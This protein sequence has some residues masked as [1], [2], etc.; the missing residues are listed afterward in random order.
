MQ[1]EIWTLARKPHSSTALPQCLVCIRLNH[2]KCCC[3]AI[4]DLGK[5]QLH[6]VQPTEGRALTFI[7]DLLD[8]HSFNT[9]EPWSLCQGDCNTVTALST[10][11][12]V[13]PP[14][15]KKQNLTG[16]VR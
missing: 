16:I 10:E 13:F 4:S 15:D 6:L 2:V 3:S 11:P 14:E 9:M 7:K 8:N 5:R 1:K 12:F